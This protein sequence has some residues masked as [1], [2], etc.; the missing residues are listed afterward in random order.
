MASKR[1]TDD[2]AGPQTF[3]SAQPVLFTPNASA[4]VQH[5]DIALGVSGFITF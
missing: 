5:A 3:T 4:P 1:G 2:L